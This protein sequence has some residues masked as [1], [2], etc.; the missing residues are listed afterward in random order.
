[1]CGGA[2]MPVL[3]LFLL[4]FVLVL[5]I[6]VVVEILVFILVL[7]L[8]TEFDGIDAGNGQGGSAFI[9]GEDITFVEFVFFYV[10][11]SVTF[12]ATNHK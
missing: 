7:V 1:M 3:L 10:D 12:W 2:L 9:A 5:F 8:R 4:I 6:F 11:R